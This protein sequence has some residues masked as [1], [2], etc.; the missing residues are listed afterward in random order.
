MFHMNLWFRIRTNKPYF[1][2]IQLVGLRMWNSSYPSGLSRFT[3]LGS[4]SHLLHAFISFTL[5][6]FLSPKTGLPKC[7]NKFDCTFDIVCDTNEANSR[8]NAM[9]LF[10]ILMVCW[11]ASGVM[12]MT[13]QQQKKRISQK[14]DANVP[15]SVACYTYVFETH[16]ANGQTGWMKVY[17]LA[18]SAR[19]TYIRTRTVINGNW[20]NAR[21]WC[22]AGSKQCEAIEC[23]CNCNCFVAYSF[24][25]NVKCCNRESLEITKRYNTNDCICISVVKM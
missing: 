19:F 11:S 20:K 18:K 7:I 2:E 10:L 6:S 1:R 17:L 5:G 13:N 16:G 21:V 24:E 14:D 25:Q 9:S 23:Y 15:V 4:T 22:I 8:D 3:C 12:V